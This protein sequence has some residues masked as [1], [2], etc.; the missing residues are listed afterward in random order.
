MNGHTLKLPKQMQLSKEVFVE[1]VKTLGEGIVK[2]I[3][4]K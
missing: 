1:D 4:M 3:T 2:S